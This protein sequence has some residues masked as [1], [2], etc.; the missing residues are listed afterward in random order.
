MNIKDK[1]TVDILVDRDRDIKSFLQMSGR[2][3]IIRRKYFLKKCFLGRSEE[4]E[5]PFSY[6]ENSLLEAL[7]KIKDELVALGVEMEDV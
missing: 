4:I 6:I 2:Y 7:I 1:N 3:K 5:V